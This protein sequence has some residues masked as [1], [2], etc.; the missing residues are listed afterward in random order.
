[1]NKIKTLIV[2]DELEA[3]EGIKLLVEDDDEIEILSVCK[4]GIEA[5]D[6]I[7]EHRVDLMFLD[8]QMPV[9]NGF[10]VVNS[11]SKERLPHIIFVTA[12]DQYALKAFEVHAIDYI[13]KPFTNLRFLEG[14][15]RA[16]QLIYQE[17]SHDEQKKLK[18][19]S[20]ELAGENAY[21]EAL[22]ASIEAQQRLI[23]K[24]GGKV[25][26]VPFQN[27]IWLEAY[28][29]YVKIHVKDHCYLVRERLKRLEEKLPENTFMRIHKSS[30]INTNQLVS[31]Q[32]GESSEFSILLDNQQWLKV[33]RNYKEKIRHLFK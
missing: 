14:L 10:E 1:M 16:K 25:Y 24:E 21:P 17:K 27:I 15:K 18:L 12:Y 8:I 22:I 19:L 13:L 9:I 3:R 5:I 29:Y 26:F 33:S 28:D 32:S 4:N 2:D 20:E 11:I 6:K 31:I 7:N 30:I 23:V